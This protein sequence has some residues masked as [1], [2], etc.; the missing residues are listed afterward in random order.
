MFRAG[1]ALD[2]IS[3]AAIVLLVSLLYDVA[4]E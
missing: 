1:V 3:V 4:F 2:L